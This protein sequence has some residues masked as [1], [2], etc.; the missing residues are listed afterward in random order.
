[1]TR[2][3]R[4]KK[5]LYSLND[6]CF[7]PMCAPCHVTTLLTSNCCVRPGSVISLPPSGL[8]PNSMCH[9]MALDL[10]L[11]IQMTRGSLKQI[12]LPRKAYQILA[13]S[14]LAP[15]TEDTWTK[16][17][18]KHPKSPPPAH[19]PLPMSSQTLPSDFN[20]LS[21]L[22]SF[23]KACVAGPTGLC[24]QHL[25]DVAEVPFPL[26]LP[27]GCN[28]HLG[29]RTSSSCNYSVHVHGRG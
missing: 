21:V 5:T 22:W 29:L 20:V 27:S 17:S 23:P 26:L 1:M 4:K 13:S 18:A 3:L 2:K 9:V 16:L 25:L 10:H 24:I 15:N 6:Q 8:I 11:L 28:Q 14:G 12:L 19:Q 7:H